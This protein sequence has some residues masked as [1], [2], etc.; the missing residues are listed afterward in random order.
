MSDRRVETANRD[1]G[2][3]RAASPVDSADDL[4]FDRT[5][6]STPSSI[7]SAVRPRW[8]AGLSAKAWTSAATWRAARDRRQS[9][10]RGSDRPG[11]RP[12][13]ARRSGAAPVRPSGSG[14][15]AD[16]APGPAPPGRRSPSPPA[17][18]SRR[19]SDTRAA[20]AIVVETESGEAGGG[21]RLGVA[22]LQ[23]QRRDELFQRPPWFAG[24]REQPADVE[25][26]VAVSGRS[27]LSASSS[28]SGAGGLLVGE[29]NADQ[30]ASGLATEVGRREGRRRIERTLVEP[31]RLGDVV[32]PS[33]AS[34]ASCRFSAASSGADSR[35]ASSASPRLVRSTAAGER[36]GEGNGVGPIVPAP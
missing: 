28:A 12:R 6:R 8:L 30:F 36:V 24:L 20:S 31:Y 11:R 16:R 32:L 23:M 29:Q 22:R 35:I 18:S 25:M 17:A 15:P 7:V 34:R 5:I 27:V 19:S 26:A 2:A 33:A 10:R 3:Y 13:S 9:P 1:P 21:E 14:P 4:L